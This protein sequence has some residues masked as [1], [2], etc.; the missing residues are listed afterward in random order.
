MA[1]TNYAGSTIAKGALAV[2]GKVSA[3]TLVLTV[4]VGRKENQKTDQN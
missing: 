4:G 1:V 2:L 3:T